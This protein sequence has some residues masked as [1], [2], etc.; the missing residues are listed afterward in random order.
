MSDHKRSSLPLLLGLVTIG[1]IFGIVLTTGFN[2]DTKGAANPVEK[3]YAESE[4]A[5]DVNSASSSSLNVN[6]NNM[7][8]DIVKKVRPSIVS[9]YTSKSVKI[10][11]DNPFYYFFKQQ[12]G[13]DELPPQEGLGSGIIISKDG[14]ILT[15]NHVVSGV[16]ELTVKMIDKTEYKA[17]LIGTDPT[18]EV[19]L[20]KIEAD[21]LPAVVLG[22]SDNVQ[23]GEWVLA[24]GSPLNL[25]STVTAGIVSALGRD[26]NIIRSNNNLSGI[27]D[28]IQTDA[29]I[30]PG[31]SGG[32]LLNIK[33]QVIGINTAIAS[34]TSYYVGYGF[35]VPIN[36][37]KSVVDD[38]LKYGEVKRG[39]LGVYIEDMDPIKTK[40]VGLDKIKGVFISSVIADGAAE[41][42]GL[43]AGDVVLSVNGKDINKRNELQAKIGTYNPGDKVSLEVW[44]DGKKITIA[45][46]LQSKSGETSI[47]K[48]T[49]AVK[50]SKT[51][52]DLG[53]KVKDLNDRQLAELDLDNGVVVA[54]VERRSAA[55][56]AGLS[57]GDVI[58]DVANNMVKSVADFYD[59]FSKYR[60]G[61]VVRIKVRRKMRDNIFD[62]LMFIQIPKQDR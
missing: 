5:A 37:A 31:N 47:S 42:A 39:Y 30:N 14:Y 7:F 51:S 23:I 11:K 24:I 22:N 10:N 62:R 48:K 32:A 46:V 8:V 40:G 3:I 36:I 13:T 52:I 53:M 58:Y 17:K 19:A 38:L 29:A 57:Q 45:A 28:F 60:E 56:E 12:H 15:N 49:E 34:G 61:D 41:K 4:V 9:I 35:A 26:V 59:I 44:R 6:P 27:E 18:T 55:A 50:E 16:D 43:K 54:V 2:L 1:I 33:G 20:I 21:N 25:T